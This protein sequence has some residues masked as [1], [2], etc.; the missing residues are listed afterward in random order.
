MKIMTFLTTLLLLTISF[1]STSGTLQDQS[2]NAHWDSNLI[3]EEGRVD[4][5][6][7]SSELND[8]TFNII[9]T[10]G[11]C[12]VCRKGKACGNSCINKN[13]SCQQPPGCACDG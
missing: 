11:C 10:G 9:A 2:Q 4:Q 8:N 5:S 6:C 3:S 7:A 1:G 12:K 13:Y